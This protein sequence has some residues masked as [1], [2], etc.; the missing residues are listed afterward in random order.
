MTFPVLGNVQYWANFLY[1][2][3]KETL[4]YTVQFP[5]VVVTCLYIFCK[6]Q[7][8]KCPFSSNGDVEGIAKMYT[9]QCKI[10]EF[11]CSCRPKM[12]LKGFQSPIERSIK[13]TFHALVHLPLWDWSS[14][15]CMH[16]RFGH[17]DLGDWKYDCGNMTI[18]RYV[19][20]YSVDL[21]GFKSHELLLL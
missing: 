2:L 7:F 20:D 19:L 14:T 9:T 10:F 3:R 6:R 12:H 16:I 15:S 4:P 21:L 17:Q 8:R 5:S 11:S 1:N 13:I 18:H